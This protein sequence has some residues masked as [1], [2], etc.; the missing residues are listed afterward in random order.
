MNRVV[1]SRWCPRSIFI[2][3]TLEIVI[4]T[5]SEYSPEIGKGPLVRLQKRL[6]TGVRKGAMERSST[7]HAAHAKYVGLLSL[8]PNIGVRLIPV[9]LR[10][11]PPSVG[12][13][14]ECL[15]LNQFQFNLPLPDITTNR[16]LRHSDFR[17]LL[18]YPRPDPVRCVSLLSWRVL[19]ALQNGF[20]EG[21]RRFYPWLTPRV[22]LSLPWNRISQRFPY[23]APVDPKLPGHSFDRSHPVV[24]LP[25]NL[26]E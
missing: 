16:A 2:Y 8:S 5:K 12:L 1:S 18:P 15:V 17:K 23:H 19:V 20:D 10:F 6:L 13:R 25:S 3:C 26:F 24:I 22:D 21:F 14:N 11:L 7:G 4:P 9:H